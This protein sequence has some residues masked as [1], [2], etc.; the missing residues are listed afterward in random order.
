MA[1][2]I[3][4]EQD[5]LDY[6]SEQ[7]E[8]HP[9][10]PSSVSRELGGDDDFDR[11]IAAVERK[12]RAAGFPEFEVSDD[13]AASSIDAINEAF[14]DGTSVAAYVKEVLALLRD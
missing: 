8:L 14:E 12:V 4:D 13:D 2:F 10:S 3:S 6:L 5:H 9:F 7:L 1:R 11:Y